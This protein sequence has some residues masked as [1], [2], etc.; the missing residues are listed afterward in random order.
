MKPHFVKLFAALAF[1]AVLA[2]VGGVVATQQ[3]AAQTGAQ[4]AYPVDT[5][6]VNGAG[7]ASGSPDT[8]TLDVG[9]ETINP[10]VSAAFTETN[11]KI[12]QV[13]AAVVA[14]GVARED[15]RTS[16][17]SI[18]SEG[19]FGPMG[20]D[21]SQRSYRVANQ[22]NVTVRDIALIEDVITAAVEA[23]ANNIFGPNFMIADPAALEQDARAE[24]LENARVRAQQ[25]A[26]LLGVD[27]GE[28]I[29]VS[30]GFSGGFPSFNANAEMAAM[31]GGGAIIEPGR[32][33]VNVNLE[34]TFRIAR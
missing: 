6:T 1:I 27:L 3:S 7:V 32:L 33:T 31:G 23:G 17:L 26:D 30:E 24:A 2:L 28:V 5:I 22:V 15:I 34:V 10:D 19:G 9:V 20:P 16:G 11:D 4:E 8:A 25:I 13:I 21:P 29:I 14:A 18:Y 12:E